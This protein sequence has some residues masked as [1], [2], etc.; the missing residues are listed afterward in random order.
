MLN[1]VVARAHNMYC[2]DVVGRLSDALYGLTA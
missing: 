1:S 2:R